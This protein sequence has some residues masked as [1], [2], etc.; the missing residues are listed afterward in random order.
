MGDLTEELEAKKNAITAAMESYS[1]GQ[2]M[3]KLAGGHG[4]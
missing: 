2:A 1:H 3:T 4:P